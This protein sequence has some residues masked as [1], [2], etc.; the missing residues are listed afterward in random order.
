[1]TVQ[2]LSALLLTVTM[3][4]FPCLATT[5]LADGTWYNFW[6]AD[7]NNF[8]TNGSSCSLG[9]PSCTEPYAA[10][11]DPP[12]T[13]DVL[14]GGANFVITDG[15]H[16]GDIFTVFNFGSTLGTTSNVAVDTNH[17]CGGFPTACLDDPAMSHGSFF[18][19]PGSYSIT[20]QED[21][22]FEPSFLAWFQV[23]P[24]TATPEPATFL[25]VGL[26]LTGAGLLRRRRR[27]RQAKS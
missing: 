20:I 6:N 14:T 7:G 2:R 11:G 27:E 10:P 13:F 12:W 24:V 21:Q 8:A 22:F 16:Q 23:D 1:M 9:N 4:A 25:L 15:G 5:I 19:A 17:D 3:G 18:L 26:T